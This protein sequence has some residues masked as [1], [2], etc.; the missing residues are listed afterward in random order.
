MAVIQLTVAVVAVVCTTLQV[1]MVLVEPEVAVPEVRILSP[2]L[3][4]AQT[5]VAAGEVLAEMATP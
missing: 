4:Q 1:G 5:L 3:T 2:L